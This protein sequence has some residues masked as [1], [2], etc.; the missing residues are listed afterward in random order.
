MRSQNMFDG[1]SEMLS[2]ADS[3]LYQEKL[4]N[5][6]LDTMPLP[7]PEL[8]ELASKFGFKYVQKLDA[9]FPADS[10]ILIYEPLTGGQ[11]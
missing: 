8:K 2:Q 4:L 7:M 3:F 1:L 6:F 5:S 10:E 11:L 9:F